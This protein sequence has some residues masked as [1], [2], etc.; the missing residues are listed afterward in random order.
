M[1]PAGFIADSAHDERYLYWLHWYTLIYLDK[2]SKAKY[3]GV[4]QNR[5]P[6]ALLYVQWTAFD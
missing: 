5:R 1:V 3:L 6:Q 2:K 4:P